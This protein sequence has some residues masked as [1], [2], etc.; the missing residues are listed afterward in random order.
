M[1]VTIARYSHPF[2]AQVAKSRLEAQG[3]PA[4]IA[5]EH[6]INMLWLYSQAMGGVRLQVPRS[7][8]REAL[9]ALGEDDSQVV[10]REQGDSTFQCPQ[11]SQEGATL[12]IR[13][14]RLAFLSILLLNVPLWPIRRELS[15]LVCK[16]RWRLSRWGR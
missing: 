6:M 8:A 11:C 10:E 2:D 16:A 1:L 14:R 4:F 5:D 3:L 15:C 7:C 9:V 12:Q 13:G